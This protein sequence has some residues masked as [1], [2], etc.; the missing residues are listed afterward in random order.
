MRCFLSLW[1]ARRRVYASPLLT[2]FAAAIYLVPGA[3]MALRY[4]GEISASDSWRFLTSHWVHW[5]FEH[6]VWS[7]GAFLVLGW[8]CEG[9]GRIRFLATTVAAALAI[10][11]ALRLWQPG[12]EAYGGLSGIDSALFGLLCTQ[13]IRKHW[14]R[15]D[16]RWLSL[17]TIFFGGFLVK[18]A[19]EYSTLEAIF[20]SHTDAMVP[21]PLAHLVGA[22]VGVIAAFNLERI[23]LWKSE[24]FCTR[25]AS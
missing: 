16:W 25:S 21:V 10:P 12:L 4:V 18:L 22:A 1:R 8:V 20:V 23:F 15:R 13:E 24:T 17:P 9:R 11:V 2:L 14:I 7:G 6:L 5:S 19:Y 3:D